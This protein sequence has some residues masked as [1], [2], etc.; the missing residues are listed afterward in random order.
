MRI[1]GVSIGSATTTAYEYRSIRGFS[2]TARIK[3]EGQ[4]YF[5][6]YRAYWGMPDYADKFVSAALQGGTFLTHNM[7]TKSHIYREECAK[8]GSVYWNVW[9]YVIREIEDAINDCNEGCVHCNDVPVHSWDEAVAFYAGSLQ[10][11]DGSGSGKLLYQLA[12]KR[13]QNYGTCTGDNAREGTAI[14][15]KQVLEQFNLGQAKLASGHCIDIQPIKDRVV[16]LMTVPLIQGALR[17]AYKVDKLGGGAKEKAEMVAF[18][19]AVLPR[20]AACNVTDAKHIRSNMFVGGI[21]NDGFLSVKS[22]FEK[23]YRCLGITCADVGGLMLNDGYYDEFTPCHDSST[24]HKP[25]DNKLWA[26]PVTA[27]L[28]AIVFVLLG[29]VLGMYMGTVTAGRKCC[30][31]TGRLSL[32]ALPE[33][34]KGA[35][36]PESD[37]GTTAVPAWKRP[38]IGSDQVT[39]LPPDHGTDASLPE[40]SKPVLPVFSSQPEIAAV[41][42]PA[43]EEADAAQDELGDA[44]CQPVGGDFQ[45]FGFAG[46]PFT[47]H[48]G[49]EK[50][51]PDVGQWIQ[52]SNPACCHPGGRWLLR[53]CFVNTNADGEDG[54]VFKTCTHCRL[55]D[56]EKK[57]QK[58]LRIARDVVNT[59]EKITMLE[60]ELNSLQDSHSGALN[61][62]QQL[63]AENARLRAVWTLSGATA[64]VQS[65]STPIMLPITQEGITSISFL[66]HMNRNWVDAPSTSINQ[67]VQ[68][69]SGQSGASGRE[70]AS[71]VVD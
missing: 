8:K 37:D 16:S 50:A 40:K 30:Y 62:I 28:S 42:P 19:G 26:V 44:L 61:T 51:V 69:S 48:C 33:F 60:T 52:C 35:G 45:R 3:M 9:M 4:R 34:G 53:A 56:A 12:N 64:A 66:P 59:R 10:G 36:G 20:V 29:V 58:R 41:L 13:C 22:A 18:T 43:I 38:R 17:Y 31:E 71:A 49:S 14:V 47:C 63:S 1:A 55:I 27:S 65:E 24:S 46:E 39:P 54:R 57:R 6:A 70:S 7:S 15:N 25:N 2:T 5:Q 21:V 68:S 23:N 67:V 11:A 32:S